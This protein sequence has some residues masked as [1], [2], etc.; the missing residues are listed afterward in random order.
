M[1]DI[2][3]LLDRYRECSRNLCN[4]HFRLEEDADFMR[5]A[6]AYDRF[7]EVD[8]V[9]FSALVL[10]D[11][12]MASHAEKYGVE[13]LP[14]LRV[15]PGAPGPSPIHINRPSPDGNRYWDEKVDRV[16]GDEAGLIFV[17]YY[18]YNIYGFLDHEF[19]MTRITTF[20]RHP[21][22][23]GRDALMRV[24]YARVF[25]DDAAAEG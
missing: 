17:S 15:I 20:D 25:L 4:E 6:D 19:Y 18:D 12:G 13:P 16:T 14:F 21:H 10:V 9:L 24:G 2:T 11:I 8:K 3:P 23:V 5:K 1:K 7:A 22:L